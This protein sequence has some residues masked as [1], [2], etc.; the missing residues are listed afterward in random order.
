MHS[1]V[2]RT[3]G[4]ALWMGAAASAH[5]AEV[6]LTGWA[7]GSANDVQ[8]TGYSGPAGAF[9]GSLAG[10]GTFDSAPFIT[11]CI[12]LEEHFTFSSTP[13]TGYALVGGA[14]YFQSHRADAGIADR[15][16]RLMTFVAGQPAAANASLAS[17]ALQLAVWNLVYDTDWVVTSNSSFR[18]QSSNK[19]A[20][21]ALLAGAH[22]TAT[23]AFDVYALEKAGSQDFLLLTLHGSNV[24]TLP[25]TPLPTAAVPEPGSL[26]L[27]GGALA[28][29]VGVGLRRRRA[30]P[31]A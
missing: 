22:D 9:G 8:A 31:A 15:I 26:A 24:T 20:A 18:D 10:A 13:M 30:A 4:I 21:N 19:T 28:A 29:M 17:T 25:G 1:T 12:E 6:T 14:S 27:V 2:L 7:Y 16:G 3:L 23:S 5:S 11:Y